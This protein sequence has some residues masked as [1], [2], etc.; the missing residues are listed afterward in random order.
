MLGAGSLGVISVGIDGPVRVAAAA[1]SAVGALVAL[2]LALRSVR[3][4]LAARFPFLSLARGLFA[5]VLAALAGSAVVADGVVRIAVAVIC[6]IATYVVLLAITG[7][8]RREDV[9]MLRRVI[10]R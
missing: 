4:T 10:G 6:A 5:G 2:V 3:A 8:V 7:E 9:A 1:G